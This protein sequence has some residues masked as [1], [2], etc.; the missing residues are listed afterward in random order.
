MYYLYGFNKFYSIRTFEQ[1]GGGLAKLAGGKRSLPED[2]FVNPQDWRCG[3]SPP[4][5]LRAPPATPMSKME[6]KRHFAHRTSVGDVFGVATAEPKMW[7][8]PKAP[9]A[10]KRLR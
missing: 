9:T 10:P 3:A 1:R 8:S 5:I 2:N 7:R 6:A 4:H